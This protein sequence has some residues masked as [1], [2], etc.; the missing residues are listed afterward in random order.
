LF[1]GNNGTSQ[2]T[3][4]PPGGVHVIRTIITRNGPLALAFNQAQDLFSVNNFNVT[5]YKPGT[6]S[7]YRTISEGIS[8]PSTLALDSAGNLYVAN[9]G[10]NMFRS[11]ISIYLPGQS[12]PI[13]EINK[14]IGYPLSLTFDQAGNLYVA[15][16]AL[17]TVTEYAP[18]SSEVERTIKKR[19]VSPTDLT[20]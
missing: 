14:G 4:Y 6:T 17:S 9:W 2:I 11:S 16:S 13:R 1:V 12:S 7:P 10:A 15:N 18:G 19:I 3:V 8:L 5:V 20:I